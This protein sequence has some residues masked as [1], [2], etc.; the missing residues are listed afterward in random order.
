MQRSSLGVM[1]YAIWKTLG[2]SIPTVLEAQ[3]GTITK[4]K[5]DARLSHWARAV[6]RHAEVN[7][8]VNGLANVP[9][10]RAFILMSN[11][12][13]HFDIP[14]LYT[15]FDRSMRMVAKAELFNVPIWGRAMR[16]AGFVA[17]DRQGNREEARAAMER[18]GKILADG[19]SVWI[20][21]EGTRSEDG[22]LGPFK[23]GGF[24]LALATHTPIVPVGIVGSRQIM[25]KHGRRIEVGVPVQINFGSPVPVADGATLS[26]EAAVQVVSELTV[27]IR[28]AIRN[29]AG[30]LADRPAK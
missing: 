16:A 2:I 11:H 20:A 22:F 13:S 23:K 14:L 12:E 6:I 8:S 7:L 24:R 30:N 21:P 5:S 18:A 1:A 17:V 29:L 10:D 9:T 28:E 4:E 26:D 15:A 19:T 25:P 27:R 3:I